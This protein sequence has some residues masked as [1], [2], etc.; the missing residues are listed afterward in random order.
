MVFGIVRH[1]SCETSAVSRHTAWGG[2]TLG[3]VGVGVRRSAW[4]TTRSTTTVVL[5]PGD[6]WPVSA[7]GVR[8]GPAARIR[9]SVLGTPSGRG[10]RG[11]S[12]PA[13]RRHPRVGCG[14]E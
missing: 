10:N 8:P 5:W 6:A 4:A 3:G 11:S 1:T 9:R 14:G 2:A 13:R 7:R 12:R